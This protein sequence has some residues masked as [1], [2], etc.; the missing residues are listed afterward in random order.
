M[1][2]YA[3]TCQK[4]AERVGSF[5]APRTRLGLWLRD[6]FYR[7]FTSRLLIGQFE[8]LVKA[9]ATAFELPEYAQVG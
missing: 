9:S 2:P 3:T 4:G 8:K 6:R 7:A 1:R 5:F